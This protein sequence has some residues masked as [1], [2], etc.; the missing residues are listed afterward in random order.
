M[1]FNKMT[2]LQTLFKR[3]QLAIF[4]LTVFTCTTIFIVISAYTMEVLAKQSINV[5]SHALSERIQPAVVF[6]DKVTINKILNEYSKHYPIRYIQV[7]DED[8]HELSSITL[9]KNQVNPTTK[10]LDRLFFNVP[11]IVSIQHNEQYYGKLIVYGN[12]SN[13]VN[14]FNHILIGLLIASLL[15]L[16]VL[17][18]FVRFVYQYLMSSITPMVDTARQIDQTKDYKLRLPN[19]PIKEIQ[20]IN[21]VFNELLNKVQDSNQQLQIENDLL[22]HQAKHDPLTQLPNRTYFYQELLQLFNQESE[23]NT[24]LFFIDN[25][26]FKVINDKFG[27]QAGDAVLKEMAQRLKDHLNPDDFIARLGGDEFAILIKNIKQHKDLEK[28]S[29]HLLDC[30]NHPVHYD[31]TEIYFSFSIGIALFSGANSPEDLISAADNAMYKAKMMHQHWYL[32]PSK[33]VTREDYSY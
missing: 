11:V 1:F 31:K 3:S 26:N 14:F 30:S 23:Y 20:G 22:S 21:I 32:S 6:N 18:I 19:S 12:S 7:L 28:V 2:S 33:D 13:L 9:Q 4:G 29:K 15:I 16:T 8:S 27:H 24:A 17:S 5:L 10:L 25:N